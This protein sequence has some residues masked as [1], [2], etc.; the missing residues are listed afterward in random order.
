MNDPECGSSVGR[1]Q[2]PVS[3]PSGTPLWVGGYCTQNCAAGDGP[4]P[5]G[6][7][8]LPPP[9]PPW[10]V[11]SC[12]L[13]LADC[14]PDYACA[15]LGG[16]LGG[17]CVPRCRVNQDCDQASGYACRTCDGL[18]VL[19]GTGATI[20]DLCTDDNQCGFGQT[21]LQIDSYNPQ[22][23][24]TNGCG[25]GCAMCPMGSSCHPI[26]HAGGQFFCLRDCVGPGTCPVGLQC[27]Q[28]STGRGCIPRC[29]SDLFCPV[30]TFCSGGEC[31]L[32]TPMD[33][34]CTLCPPED[35]GVIVPRPRDSGIGPPS[36]GPGC[37]CRLTPAPLLLLGP[38]IFRRKRCPR[39]P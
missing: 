22:R 28:L 10:C 13:G 32:P 19:T 14:R 27:G 39:R 9:D 18:C 20:G 17:G 16:G 26:P 11:Q 2:N 21:C 7:V 12:R 30:G 8:C 3:L 1:C 25:S 23:I 29:T 34:G 4:C 36:N 31:T 24:C 38:L 35:S 33:G 5:A 6:S 37:G 15:S